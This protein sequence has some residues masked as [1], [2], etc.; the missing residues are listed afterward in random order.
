MYMGQYFMA[1][2][3][4]RLELNGVSNQEESIGKKKNIYT[5]IGLVD[6]DR[7]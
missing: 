7:T 6:E 2:G 4:T 3:I 5:L 1:L